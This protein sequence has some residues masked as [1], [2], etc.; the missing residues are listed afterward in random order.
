VT[1]G[2][3]IVA[4]DFDGTI[5][6]HRFPEVGAP[7]PLALQSIRALIAM[8]WRVILWTMRSGKHLDDAVEFLKRHGIEPWAVNANPTQSG[9]TSSPKAYAHYYV[10]DAALGCP[11]RRFPGF[12]RPAVDW[13]R[14]GH[15]LLERELGPGARLLPDDVT[16]EALDA[17]QPAP[18][19]RVRRP[20]A[21]ASAGAP[22]TD[23]PAAR[24]Q[25]LPA[26]KPRQSGP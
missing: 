14:V 8:R 26:R 25:V 6:D 11:L 1:D 10:D 18:P 4:I 24:P 2:T 3:P 17:G 21:P 13:H 9:W 5:V 23:R 16:R 20:A 19:R 15:M 12:A 22:A 7:V